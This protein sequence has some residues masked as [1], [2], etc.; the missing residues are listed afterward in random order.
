MPSVD[1]FYEMQLAST[2]LFKTSGVG[3]AEAIDVFESALSKGQDVFYAGIDYEL[4]TGSRTALYSAK[5]LLL[6]KYPAARIELP[7]THSIAPGLGLLLTK[8]SRIREDGAGLDEMLERLDYWSHH[9]AHWFSVDNFDQLY[10][11]GRA[12]GI[13]KY[14]ATGFNIKP[15]MVLPH[16]GN[17]KVKKMA[18]GE[19]GILKR[20][21]EEVRDTILE[22][23]GEVWISFGAES[24]LPRVNKLAEMI[25]A[26]K[27]KAKISLHRIGPVI[28]AHVG[29]TVIA[30]FFFA[31]ER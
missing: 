20:F 1:E 17:L 25:R 13:Q 15:F 7:N 27:P 26:F 16:D 24:Q 30:V 8:L 23:D 5:E 22:D 10:Y 6:E 31:R 21:A 28:G 29:P 12:T 2:Q 18:R 4:S 3:L 14:L 19:A 11:S 9:I